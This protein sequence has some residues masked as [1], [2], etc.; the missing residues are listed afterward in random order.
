MGC[1]S[2]KDNGDAGDKRNNTPAAAAPAASS[3]TATNAASNTTTTT[4]TTP[5]AAPAEKKQGMLLG[6]D[7]SRKLEDEYE[8][9]SELGR[10]GFA[11]VYAGKSKKTD[12]AVAIKVIEKTCVDTSELQSL[13]REIDIMKKVDHP[14]V[15]KLIDIFESDT[16]VTLVTELVTGGELFYK[17]V[18]RGSYS[19]ADAAGIVR[20]LVTGVEY[21][22]SKGIAHRDLKPENLLCS[23]GE[24]KDMVIKIADFGLSKMFSAGEVLKTSCGTP[25]Y[26]A[27]EVLQTDGTYSN[28]VDMWSVGVITYVLLCGYPPF[29]AKEQ[30][31]LF[32]QILN[33]EY[34][35]PEEDWSQISEDAKDFIRHLLVVDPN[36]R[37]TASQALKDKWL[38]G[39][40][41]GD[42]KVAIKDHLN[43]YNE[44]RRVQNS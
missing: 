2:S 13:V 27:P 41:S 29:Y 44:R 17:I 31:E 25:D 42:A 38:A 8:V 30:R 12:E 4:T 33:A 10:G 35:F 37:M 5:A 21:L 20:Q 40:V 39:E 32:T 22:H 1:A 28:A 16:R 43:E 9:G 7:S 6:G 23:D 3:S 26:A 11:V 15:L 14:N 19:E 18:E 36:E 34:E 24:G